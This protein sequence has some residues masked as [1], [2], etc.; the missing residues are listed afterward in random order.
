[1]TRFIGFDAHKSYAYVV[2][3]RDG[4]QQE[5][6]VAIPG[7]LTKFRERLDS[8]A[9]LVLEASTNSFRL[10]DELRPHVGKLV[11]AD[12]APNAGASSGAATTDRSSAEALAR[13][14]ASDFVQARLGAS[15]RDPLC[16]T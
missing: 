7:G 1:M 6:R 15:P 5:Y 2:E 11:V 13:L 14:L 12:P 10:A 4:R 9:Q 3:L 16:G 8:T